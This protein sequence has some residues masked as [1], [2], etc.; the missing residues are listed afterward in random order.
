MQL[1]NSSKLG[2]APKRECFLAASLQRPHCRRQLANRREC[3]RLQ[4]AA[5]LTFFTCQPE[6]T[7][8][9]DINSPSHL[10]PLNKKINSR[11]AKEDS[12]MTAMWDRTLLLR[13]QLTIATDG[14]DFKLAIR[15]KSEL[16]AVVSK[17]SS[18]YTKLYL[19]LE[20]LMDPTA[21]ISI[22]SAA[23]QELRL[24][25]DFS[26]L[27]IISRV[28]YTG[29]SKLKREAEEVAASI[30]HRLS[31]PAVVEL[32]R[33][34]ALHLITLLS[35]TNEDEIA[36]IGAEAVD[37]Y[38]AALEIDEFCATALAGRGAVF[39][40]S[41][42]FEAA[43]SDLEAAVHLDPW[44]TNAARMLALTH[45]Q[46]KQ[47]SRAYAALSAAAVHN[48]S[49]LM[50]NPQHKATKRVI[51]TWEDESKEWKQRYLSM[52]E[53]VEKKARLERLLAQTPPPRMIDF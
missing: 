2:L 46:L 47:F 25:G 7:N 21:G 8:N 50:D 42:Q 35:E 51:Q 33:T 34:G 49:L 41:R 28:A 29:D 4:P 53:V 38:S 10:I 11:P 31:S 48:P 52:R 39:Y 19:L 32:C 36:R 5:A 26:T 24:H 12:T 23:L 40:C 6:D 17:L 45:G 15:I 16:F 22:K 1:L 18:K 3:L 9:E 27:P 20:T 44:N 43:S 30:R 14:N 37:V 13:R